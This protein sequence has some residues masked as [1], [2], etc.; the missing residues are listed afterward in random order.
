MRRW[1]LRSPMRARR[2]RWSVRRTLTTITRIS[3]GGWNCNRNRSV[4]IH[5]PT[6]IGKTGLGMLTNNFTNALVRVTRGTGATQERV[7]TANDANTLTVTPPWVVEPDATSF[8]VVAE[9][10]WTFGG[11]GTNSPVEFEIPNRPGTTVEI[12]GRSANVYDLESAYELNP[13]TRW[14]IGG[15]G[16]LDSGTPPTPVFGLNPA[17]QG[18]IELLGIGFTTLVNTHTIYVGTLTLYSWNELNSPATFFLASGIAATDV[19]LTLNAAG[20]ANVGDLI[21]IEGEI[22]EVSGTSGGGVTYQVIRGSRGS[23]A[24]AHVTSKLVYHLTRSITIVPFVKDFFG[25]PASGSFSYSV[26]L[27]DARVGAADFYVNNSMGSS[28]VAHATFGA[29]VDQGQRTLAGGQISIQVQGYLAIQTNAAPPLVIEDSHAARDMFA[30]VQNAPSGGA[31]VMQVRQGST[32]YCTLT[33][34][35][36]ATISNVVSGFGLPPLVASALL[37]LDITAV[38]TAAGTLPGRDLTLIIRL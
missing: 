38:P 22:L 27:P 19:A 1:R 35:D 11:L 24:A 8:F 16:G 7:V 25:S 5:S 36:G 37:N 31:I 13:V 15:A 3:I 18:T 29:T 17:G 6:S 12:S 30:V 34:P 23:T 33:I 32:I 14:Q 4:G 9:G 28:A 20:P 21:Q 26:F 10:T 2:R